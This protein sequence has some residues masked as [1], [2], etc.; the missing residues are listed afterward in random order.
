MVLSKRWQRY[1]DKV[2]AS[3]V[4]RPLHTITPIQRG[5]K[6][7][8]A[9]DLTKRVNDGMSRWIG[10][11]NYL[12]DEVLMEVVLRHGLL[13]CYGATELAYSVHTRLLY[14]CE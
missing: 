6:V 10:R 5:G 1:T 13:R 14:L 7:G 9:L 8:D 11:E 4:G 2:L 3:V 12:V